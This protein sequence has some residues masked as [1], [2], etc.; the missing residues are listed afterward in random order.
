MSIVGYIE[1]DY[2]P[3]Y[4]DI[5]EPYYTATLSTKCLH[6][7]N[8]KPIYLQYINLDTDHINKAK[9]KT[10]SLMPRWKKDYL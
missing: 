6:S 7:F 5:A 9:G 2:K 8:I 4:L 3:Y 1:K 10:S